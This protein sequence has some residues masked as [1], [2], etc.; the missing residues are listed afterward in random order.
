MDGIPS[1]RQPLQRCAEE[2]TGPH[3]QAWLCHWVQ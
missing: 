3:S 2:S 1:L